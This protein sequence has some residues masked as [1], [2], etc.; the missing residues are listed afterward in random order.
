MRS[1]HRAAIAIAVC[2]LMYP[3]WNTQKQAIDPSMP[4]RDW[5]QVATF[6]SSS[7]CRARSFELLR[8]MDGQIAHSDSYNEDEQRR[9]RA[10]AQCIEEN[11]PRLRTTQV[12]KPD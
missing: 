11:D 7:E 3:P 9:L 12:P 8:Q 2:Y 1:Y 6:S 4:I 5:Y 10:D